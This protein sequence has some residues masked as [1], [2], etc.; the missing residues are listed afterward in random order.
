V[1]PVLNVITNYLGLLFILLCLGLILFYVFFGKK[2]KF[3][4]RDLQAFH[5][6]RRE[7]DLAVE[8]GMRL[9]ISLGRGNINDLQGGAAFI[10]LTILD[11][12]ARA[13]SNSD[14]PLVTT[15]GD[16]VLT[17]LSQD[18]LQSTY[19]SLAAEQR[20]DP[21]NARLT[22]LT[23]MAYAAGAIPTIHDEHVIV[24]F[25]TGHF[26]TEV[27]LLTEA[28]ERSQSLTVAG[29]DSI[30][31]Q[32]IL[33]AASDEPLLGEELYA[34]GACLGANPAHIAS[35]RMQDIL[36]WILAGAIVIGAILKLLRILP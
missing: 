28:G 20:Y 24:N 23:P 1:E 3:S 16:G 17:I 2:S 4:L 34:A 10:G 12:C 32:A 11:R 7:V 14:R 30:P 6:F 18:T 26:G 25:F 35:L 33:Y 29:T 21:T 13:A 31:A 22:G 19:R 27:A 15:A 36:R 5:R 8:A 9:H